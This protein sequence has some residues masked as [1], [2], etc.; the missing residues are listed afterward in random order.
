MG[1]PR[2]WQ[3]RCKKM[4]SLSS[5]VA[6]ER[7]TQE[8][9]T[10]SSDPACVA[11][12]NTRGKWDLKIAR[13]MMQMLLPQKDNINTGK[14]LSKTLFKRKLTNDTLSREWLL[15]SPSKGIV[16][17]FTC[18]LFGNSDIQSALAAGYSD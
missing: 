1:Q 15:H 2:S 3:Q 10:Y 5:L 7:R 18:K 11:Q 4:S 6:V 13:I 9:A 16:F 12:I 17:C 8:A 14:T